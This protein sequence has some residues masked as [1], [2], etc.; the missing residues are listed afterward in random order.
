M[1]DFWIPDTGELFHFVNAIDGF[2]RPISF[3]NLSIYSKLR[4]RDSLST[5]LSVV[6]IWQWSKL[7][8][9]SDLPSPSDFAAASTTGNRKIFMI[10]SILSQ[11]IIVLN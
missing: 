11:V 10:V 2:F 5:C 7:T 1:G 6:E 8:S 9:F 3:C 4:Y